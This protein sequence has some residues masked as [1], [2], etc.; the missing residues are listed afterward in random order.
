V[1]R[2]PAG[3]VSSAAAATPETFSGFNSI[4]FEIVGQ[5]FL[6]IGFVDIDRTKRSFRVICLNPMGVKLFDLSGDERSTTTN[7]ALEPLAKAGDIAAA[8]G[9]DIRRVYFDLAPRSN[10]TP[11]WADG[12][13]VYGGGV[14]GGY[15]EHVFSG[16]SGELIEKRFYDEQLISW[17]VT[18]HDYR[19]RG[20]KRI[21]GT[22][23]MTSYQ[24]GYRLT[25]REK[26]QTVDEDQNAD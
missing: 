5:K 18:Y 6:G 4:V 11:R 1:V 25:I 17:Q 13:L 15:A 12:D 22:I 9:N 19:E 2:D 26:E 23:V 8:V 20:G 14:P 24:G 16:G 21:P 3:I 10:A 7:F